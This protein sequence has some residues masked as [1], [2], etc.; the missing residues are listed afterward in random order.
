MK[1]AFDQV[2]RGLLRNGYS[3][4]PL[5]PRTKRP[6]YNG[7]Q[8]LRKLPLAPAG[9]AKVLAEYPM[10]GVGVAGSFNGLVPVDVDAEDAAI[11]DRVTGI[12]PEPTVA[13]TGQKGWTAFYR[14][15]V[16]ACKLKD[17]NGCTM[18]EVLTTGQ[19]VI[20]PTI[21]P[22]TG[23]PY[24]WLTPSTLLDTRVS[25]LP[26]VTEAHVEAI[27]E[28]LAPFMRSRQVQEP[29][30]T[31]AAP[32]PTSGRLEAYAR[33]VIDSEAANLAGV[34]KGGRHAA[35]VRAGCVMGKWVH[36]GHITQGTVE[37]ALYRACVSNGLVSEDG[38]KSVMAAIRFGIAKA[39]NDALPAI[40][41][42]PMPLKGRWAQYA[43]MIR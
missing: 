14:G 13:K 38:G 43:E 3:P 23:R 36:H 24:R 22:D 35:A 9:I 41:D 11:I 42:R 39:E 1:G 33:A 20:P 10:A 18:V 26:E 12:L 16:N 34:A 31:D 17:A 19:T 27:R 30:S 21:H 37:A 25:D 4:V 6:W 15:Q 28:A 2:H 5:L 7:W 29:V 32:A 40:V 8:S